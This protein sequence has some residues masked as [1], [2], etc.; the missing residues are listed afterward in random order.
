MKS[1]LKPIVASDARVLVLGSLPGDKS[2]QLQQYYANP[3]NDFWRIISAVYETPEPLSYADKLALLRRNRVALWDVPATADRQGS[4]DSKIRN[5]VPNDIREVTKAA[6]GIDT[7][8]LNGR[9][10]ELYFDRHV[11]EQLASSGVPIAY[12]PS[13]SGVPGKNV[14]SLDGKIAKWRE[15]MLGGWAPC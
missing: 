2:I 4:A 5:P 10:A 3:Q 13:S 9:A 8:L 7:I 1:G 6:P 15:A 12:V 11:R 14:L